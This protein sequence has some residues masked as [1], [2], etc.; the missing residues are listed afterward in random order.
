MKCGKAFMIVFAVISLSF[1]LYVFGVPA[2]QKEN[3]RRKS[4]HSCRLEMYGGRQFGIR[5]ITSDDLE[6]IKAI[7]I[8]PYDGKGGHALPITP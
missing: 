5:L 2:L 7:V 6:S 3:I 1:C 4:E 8:L